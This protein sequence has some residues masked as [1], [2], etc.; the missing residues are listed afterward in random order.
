MLA[1]LLAAIMSSVD[2]ALNSASTLVICD[3]V[4]PR[5]PKL[6]ARA[7][8]RL[9]RHTTLGMMFIAALW[10][11]AIDRFPGLFAYLQQAFAYVTPPLVAVFAA[12]MLSGR[13]SANA[14]F[15]GLITGHGVSAAWFI[16]TQLGWVKVHFTVVA[17]LL[18]VMTLLACALW[19][20]LLGGTVTDEQRLA[21]DASHVEPA[22]LAVRRGAAMLTALTLV[23]VIAFW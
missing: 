19:Q 17:F 1:G 6:D 13:L 3:F 18:L 23:L 2:T 14:A 9:G 16:A 20:A 12:G 21:V 8:A 7:L 11:P 22:P 4:Q 15:A 5:R 10:A